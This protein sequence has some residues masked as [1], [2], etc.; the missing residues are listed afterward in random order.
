MLPEISGVK[1]ANFTQRFAA[2]NETFSELG[3][4]QSYGVLWHQAAMGRNDEDITSAY[5][6]LSYL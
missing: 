2:Y 3:S 5:I 6:R 4:G 1:T